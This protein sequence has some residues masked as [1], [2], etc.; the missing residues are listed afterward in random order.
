[1]R[2]AVLLLLRSFSD[3][4]V[5]IGLRADARGYRVLNAWSEAYRVAGHSTSS[6]TAIGR[7]NE[8]PFLADSGLRGDRRKNLP[9]A[10]SS[11]ISLRL[12]GRGGGAP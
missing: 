4:R 2:I 7:I 5:E 3:K 9:T 10:S 8:G 11:S 6:M 1:V 12:T